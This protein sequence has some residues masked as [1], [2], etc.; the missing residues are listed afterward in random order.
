MNAIRT[1][2]TWADAW[3][4]AM[5]GSVVDSAVLLAVVVVVWW[6]M[7]GRASAQFGYCLFLL[8]LLKLLLPVPVRVPNWLAWASPRQAVARLINRQ[9]ASDRPLGPTSA[10]D[11]HETGGHPPITMSTGP[12]SDEALP[13]A[14]GAGETVPAPAA[15]PVA[16]LSLTAVLMLGWAT[17]A[18]A[19]LLAFAWV[20]GRAA[21]LL[22]RVGG[23]G[24]DLTLVEIEEA[25]RLAGVRRPA[26]VLVTPI[27]ASPAVWGVFRPCVLLPAGLPGE[28]SRGQLRWVLLHE[29]A[30]IRRGDLW[31]LLLQRVL[32]AIYFFNPVIWITNRMIDQQREYACDDA[33]LAASALPRRECGAVFLTLVERAV[34]MPAA[35]APGLGLFSYKTFVQRRLLRIL[36][37]RRPI[38][39]R[40]SR[41]AAAML[42]A[43]AAVLLP[44]L[45]ADDSKPARAAERTD[46]PQP[47]PAKDQE[48]PFVYAGRVLDATDRPLTGAKVFLVEHTSRGYR[49]S[50]RSTTDADGRFRF[51]VARSE[52]DRSRETEPWDSAMIAATAKGYGPD[53]QN[54]NRPSLA[55]NLSLHLPADDVPIKGRVVDLEGR[56][57]K[58]VTVGVGVLH[59]QADR[60]G[61]PIPFDARGETGGQSTLMPAWDLLPSST[62]D[63]DGRFTLTGVGRDRLLEISFHGPT[64][65]TRS[66]EVVTRADPTRTLPGTGISPPGKEPTKIRHGAT[67]VH[68]AAPT[69]PV[70]G[71]VRDA[72][73]GKPLA[74]MRIFKPFTRSDEPSASTTTDTEGHYRLVGLALTGE[75]ELR[76]SAEDD[77]PYFTRSLKVRLNTPGLEPVTADVVMKRRPVIDGRL[78]DK[79]TGKP[80]RAWITYRPL[81]SNPQVA[82]A[83]GEL[84]TFAE[85]GDDGKFRIPALAGKG[86]LLVRAGH[87]RNNRY[88]SARLDPADREQGILDKRD[89]LLLDTAPLPALLEEHNAYRL[90]EVSEQAPSV[91]ADLTLDPG[92]TL[93]GKV[94]D[95]DGKPL[96]GADVFSLADPEV[97]A[98]QRTLDGAEFTIYALDPSRPRRLYFY[99]EERRLGGTLVVR[100]DEAG[101]ITARLEPMGSIHGR[102]V[103][104]QGK[105]LAGAYFQVIYTGAA[106]E[107]R[108]QFPGGWRFLTPAEEKR[109]ER[110]RGYLAR[111]LI[112]GPEKSDEQGRF[113]IGGLLAGLKFDLRANVSVPAPDIAPNASRV[114]G[115]RVIAQPIVRAGED[116]DLGELRIPINRA[117]GKPGR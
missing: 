3:A 31:I 62:T 107:P 16:T 41:G 78:T 28:L 91:H 18:S 49:Y 65:E 59:C 10:A 113:R 30:H 87:A 94:V 33:A 90:V 103:D 96:A 115:D 23:D 117:L 17:I 93:A 95:P 37:G 106:D 57:I 60:Q 52:F 61:R 75:Y 86:V 25:R 22:S 6:L 43:L 116:L 69:K 29:L 50:E 7:R 20:Q 56:P 85:A 70:I 72:D 26:R 73:T 68:V 34:A 111:D 109:Q 12:G 82:H 104:G 92:R 51:T 66:A 74:N 98:H 11:I 89:P 32:Q 102:L 114:I 88:L 38:H 15:E 46:K 100:G 84:E 76:V 2:N 9:P 45:Q 48:Q 44:S 54:A 81:A 42:L 77:Q 101:P 47:E 55:T 4:A 80:V 112:L 40:L 8:V 105:P 5:L 39:D 108:I 110:V 67:F 99:H 63:G 58:G 19:W 27:V 83:P 24:A 1:V 13:V 14:E 64:I 53:W 35:A 21:W 71:V 79:V 97:G 36:D